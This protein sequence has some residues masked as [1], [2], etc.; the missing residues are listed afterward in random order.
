MK[1]YSDYRLNQQ[2]DVLVPY[3]TFE[4]IF[5]FIDSVVKEHSTEVF[6]DKYSYYNNSTHERISEKGL[7]KI[8]KDELEKRFYRHLDFDKT[9][10]SLN[11]QRDQLGATGLRI[12]AERRAIFEHN[13]DNE[14]AIKLD[15][16]GEGTV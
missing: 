10:N 1:N 14:N 3:Q 13:V 16:E 2:S 8:S 12:L 7:K 5:R 15:D 4:A 11:I 6:T 9:M